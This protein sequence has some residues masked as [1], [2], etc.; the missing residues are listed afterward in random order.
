MTDQT[1]DAIISFTKNINYDDLNKKTIE[2]AKTF[3]TDSI[4]VGISGSKVESAAAIRLTVANWG[5]GGDSS[6]LGVCG[7]LP[8]NSAAYVN[9]FQIHCQEYDCLHEGATVHAMAVLTGALLALAQVSNYSGRDL[10]LGTVIGVDI[11]ANLGLSATEGL[12]FFRPATAGALGACAALA[13]LE[14]FDDLQMRD[15]LGLTYSQLA[16]TMQAHVEGSVALPIQIAGAAR[17]VIT[18]I[19]LV[20]QKLSGPHEIMDGPFGYF[21]LFE[22]RGKPKKV[23]NTLGLTSR[24]RELSHKPFPTGRAAHAMLDGL[25]ILQKKHHIQSNNVKTITAQ[26]PPLVKRLVDR[27]AK[28]NMTVNYARLCLQ[29]LIAV[30]LAKGVID[31]GSFTNDL[32]KDPAILASAKKVRIIEDDNPDPNALSPQ[33]LLIESYDGSKWQLEIPDTL[34]S[35]QNPLTE[36]QCDSKFMHCCESGHLSRHKTMELLETLKCLEDCEDID[37]LLQMTS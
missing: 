36:S 37:K 8:A 20:K 23:F 21:T 35:P 17:A 4:A 34:G 27:P 3:L 12:A 10:I 11:A 29:Y 5:V 22:P 7:K 14:C 19:Q 16:G 25:N 18:S 31:T 28:D 26:V 24:V 1:M 15:A 6:I 33:K 32:L 2:S 13:R 9:S 30:Q